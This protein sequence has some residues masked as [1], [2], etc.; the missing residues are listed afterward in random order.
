MPVQ[1][2]ELK[3]QPHIFVSSYTNHRPAPPAWAN[4]PCMQQVYSAFNNN[5]KKFSPTAP[6]YSKVPLRVNAES[7]FTLMSPPVSIS[8]PIVMIL[9]CTPQRW[10]ALLRLRP[11]VDSRLLRAVPW[12]G[13][14]MCWA[15]MMRRM[16][17][18]MLYKMISRVETTRAMM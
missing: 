3:T 11:L 18:A 13:P 12:H 5:A 2:I 10:I 1:Y 9:P 8:I 6:R 14:W 15:V 4:G 16:L 7:T 17:P